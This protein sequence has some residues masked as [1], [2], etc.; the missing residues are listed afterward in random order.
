MERAQLSQV[1]NLLDERARELYWENVR[2]TDLVRFGKFTG[3]A[4]NWN[5]KANMPNGGGI[6]PHMDLFPIPTSVINSYPG[7]EYKQNPG[8]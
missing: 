1:D 5:W 3:T 2:R 7:G 8:Y 4:Y 6:A